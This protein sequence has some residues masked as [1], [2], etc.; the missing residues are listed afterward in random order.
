MVKQPPCSQY[1]PKHIELLSKLGMPFCRKV[2][3][4]KPKNNKPKAAPKPKANKPGVGKP[5]P[6]SQYPG[7][8]TLM[9]SKFGV[10][11][12]R[13]DRIPNRNRAGPSRPQ[14]KP[15]AEP[16]KAKRP[17]PRPASPVNQNSKNIVHL[18]QLLANIPTRFKQPIVNNRDNRMTKVAKMLHAKASHTGAYKTSKNFNVKKNNKFLAKNTIEQARA[19]RM[20]AIKAATMLRKRLGMITLNRH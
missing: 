14:R 7:P 11:Y 9:T 1:S 5:P 20:E 12:C 6:C 15:K 8:H 18:R 19:T 17:A 10:K 4:S 2:R 3:S 16:R 13:K